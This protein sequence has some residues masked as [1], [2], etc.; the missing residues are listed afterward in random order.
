MTIVESL[1]GLMKAELLAE[2]KAKGDEIAAVFAEA[3]TRAP[4]PEVFHLE[5]NFAER[6]GANRNRA[7]SAL[8]RGAAAFPESGRM[9]RRLAGH[10]LGRAQPTAASTCSVL[11]R[12]LV[13]WP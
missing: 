1:S 12:R 7:I 11:V 13:R 6:R 10:L 8:E 4:T 5:C 2:T 3:A 9:K